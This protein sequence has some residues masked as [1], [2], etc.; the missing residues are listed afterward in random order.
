KKYI[1]KMG[2]LNYLFINI[3]L[4]ITFTV[5]KF[6][7]VNI[8]PTTS[9]LAVIKYLFRYLIKIIDISIILRSK[10]SPGNIDLKV[11]GDALFTDNL[12]IRYN[13]SRYV[14]FLVRGLVF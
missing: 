14:I 10:I 8:N 11:F 2:S 12:I 4:N 5:N 1:K 9:S 6:Y 7:K 13:I 3:R